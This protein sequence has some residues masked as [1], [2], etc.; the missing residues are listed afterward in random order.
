MQDLA[1][2]GRDEG[3]RLVIDAA[4]VAAWTMAVAFYTRRVAVRMVFALLV[5]LAIL[6]L[7]ILPQAAI[8]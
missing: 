1:K 2:S 5:P 7:I 3:Q 4:R 8:G 6:A